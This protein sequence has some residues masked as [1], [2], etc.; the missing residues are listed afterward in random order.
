[1]K[2]ALAPAIGAV[3][4]APLLVAL[5]QP[6]QADMID[7][8][9]LQPWEGCALC[10]SLD[11]VSRMPRFPKLAGQEAD[12]I[13]KQ[14]RD[15]RAGRRDNDGEQMQASAAALPAAEVEAVAQYFAELPPPP[16]SAAEHTA[17]PAGQALL[18]SG[19]PARG[20][21]ACLSCHGA[22][23]VT[24]SR[25]PRLEAQHAD[26]LEKQ[27]LDFQ[28]GRRR[29]DAEGVMRAVAAALTAEEIRALAAYFS[30][31]ERH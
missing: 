4:L 14:L 16:A 18:E 20:L 23:Q 27:L 10:H 29:N 8:S 3:L 7:T 6:A 28:A 2:I 15:F 1:M 13:A 21:P 5:C 19:D 31:L 11:G 22:G 26:Y 9:G 24:Q 30:S 17:S 25:A 12:Y